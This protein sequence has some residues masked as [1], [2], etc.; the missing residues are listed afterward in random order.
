DE[1]IAAERA[2]DVAR[3]VTTF[4]RPHYNVLAL[5]AETIGAAAVSELL[6]GLF[7]SFPDFDFK[8]HR[9]HHALAATVVEGLMTG[10]HRGP[11]AGVPAS[12]KRIE[13]MCCSVFHFD[14]D[15]LTSESVYF[16]HA[17]LLAQIGVR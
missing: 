13:L 12:G 17:T 2:G 3:A 6:A 10:T 9:T 14:E 1:H 5:G 4:H 11:W 8:P 15:R 16:D 7:S